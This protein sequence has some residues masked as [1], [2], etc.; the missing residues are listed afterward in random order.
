MKNREYYIA[1]TAGKLLV[2]GR[3]F[4]YKDVEF[5]IH[6][7]NYGYAVDHILSG[8]RCSTKV[9]RTYK[10]AENDFINNGAGDEAINFIN[11]PDNFEFLARG[12]AIIN[13]DK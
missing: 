9:Y 10:E 5:G 8:F 12:V 11:D 1:T 4:L 2:K 6:K 13:G 7:V 3:S